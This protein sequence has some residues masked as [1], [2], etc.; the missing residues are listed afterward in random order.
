[1]LRVAR[2]IQGYW[3]LDIARVR[4]VWDGKESVVT[5]AVIQGVEKGFWMSKEGKEKEKEKGS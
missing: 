4:K 3:I 5:L 2:T 1:M